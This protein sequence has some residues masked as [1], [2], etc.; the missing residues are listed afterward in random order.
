MNVRKFHRWVGVAFAPFFL[1]TAITGIILF[2]RN[3]DV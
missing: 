3:D 1:I 2:W